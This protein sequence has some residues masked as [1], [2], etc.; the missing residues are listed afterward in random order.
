MAVD[1]PWRWRMAVT[2]VALLLCLGV[3]QP[4]ETRASR[5]NSGESLTLSQ[6]VLQRREGIVDAAE[7][8][9]REP[10]GQLKGRL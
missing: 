3:G 4:A 9:L 2:L 10:D 6:A 7:P 5:M 8:V 1:Q